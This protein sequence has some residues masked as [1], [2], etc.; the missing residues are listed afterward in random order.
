MSSIGIIFFDIHS[1]ICLNSLSDIH[2]ITGAIDDP[3]DIQV[4]W[5][6]NHDF[7]LGHGVP[8]NPPGMHLHP[9]FTPFLN[10]FTFFPGI[11]PRERPWYKG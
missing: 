2:S 5:S 8:F 1:N 10:P 6:P 3:D 9:S 7:S 11:T 4:I